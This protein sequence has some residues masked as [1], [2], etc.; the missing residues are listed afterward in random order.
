VPI[1]QFAAVEGVIDLGWGHPDPDLLPTDLVRDGVRHAIETYGPDSLAYGAARG[2]E[3]FLEAVSRRVSEIDG[4]A[5][6]SDE[7]LLTA[8]SSAAL[9]LVV[10]FLSRPGDIVLVD[11]PTYHL[12]LRI[13]RDHA[14]DLVEI[15]RQSDGMDI[16][17]LAALI[18]RLR[19][20]GRRPSLLYC[21]PTYGNPTGAS[22][23]ADLRRR[24]AA[25]LAREKITCIED[26]VYRELTLSGTRPDSIWSIAEPGS[27]IR[28]GSFS[29]SLG[30]GLRIGYA[31]ASAEIVSRVAE[32]GLLESGGGTAHFMSLVV[33]G[34][35]SSGD[36]GRH[37]EHLRIELAY[38]RDALIEAMAESLPSDVS[39]RTPDGGYFVWLDVPDADMDLLFAR[40]LRA[41]VGFVP[42]ATFYAVRPSVDHHIRLA[43]SR[44]AAADLRIAGARLGR[45]VW[46]T[47]T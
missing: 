7:V 8:G 15:P 28:L 39:W 26:D 6:R 37:V 3:P 9:D 33:A 2:P 47:R 46:E 4:H 17:A 5:P 44:Y 11:S 16:D 24:L 19:Q 41:G 30:P 20:A 10:G 34:L 22:L 29:K 13:L 23:P 25:L 14:V 18:R 38:R 45:A 21:V 42:G 36:Y 12:A 32:S 1:T 40:A 43:F 27:V 31:T 35:I